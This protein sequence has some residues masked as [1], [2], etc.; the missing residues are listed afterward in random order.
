MYLQSH[1]HTLPRRRQSGRLLTSLLVVALAAFTI[2]CLAAPRL[3]FADDAE[4]TAVVEETV[5]A[6]S[7][8]SVGSDDPDKQTPVVT[9]SEQRV[10]A[11]D[12]VGS[13]DASATSVDD[14]NGSDD[15]Q[16]NSND[17]ADQQ[18]EQGAPA[19][20]NSDLADGE[21]TASDTSNTETDGASDASNDDQDAAGDTGSSSAQSDAAEEQ[22]TEDKTAE[23]NKDAQSSSATTEEK[24]DTSSSA[25]A[26]GTAI[27]E[28]IASQLK[29]VVKRLAASTSTTSIDPFVIVIDAGHGGFDSG[30]VGNDLQEHALNLSIAKHIQELLQGFANVVVYM[31]RTTNTSFTSV[32]KTDLLARVNFAVEHSAD[33]FISVHTNSG[34]SSAHGIEVIA[35]NDSSYRY[36]LHT[37][38][39]GLAN[40]VFYAERAIGLAS[41]SGVYTRDYGSGAEGKYPDGSNADYL[42]LLRNCRR[43]NIPAILIENLFI[44][45]AGD[46]AYLKSDANRLKIA[47]AIVNGIVK[48]YSLSK[49]LVSDAKGLRYLNNDKTY[50]TNTFKTVGNKTYYFGSNTYAVKWEQKINGKVYYFDSD[51]HM[52]TGWLTWNKDRTRSYFGADGAAL[53]GWQTV[54]G[55]RYYFD[56]ANWCHG[57][58]WEHK[59]NGK[60]YYFDSD[61]HMWTGWLTWNKDKTRSYF[62]SDGAAVS[63]W[64]DDGKKR[65]YI[66]P[67]TLRTVRWEHRIGGKVYYFDSD[68]HMWTGWL[69]WGKDRTR[70][71]FGAD[72]AALSGWQTV[73][74]RR[75]YFDPDNWCHGYRWEHWMGGKLYYFDADCHMWTGWLTWN[76][77]KTRSYFGADGAALSGW[78]TV[79]G[80]RYYFDPTNWCHGYRWEHRIGGKVYYFDADCH[81]WTGWLTW[82]KD[83]TRSYFGADGA[84]LSGW[85]TVGGK[86]YYFDPANWCHGLRWEHKIDGKVYYF[87][88]DCH[89]WTGWLTWKK[90][91]TRSYFGADGAA[92]SG[93]QTV[94]GKRYYFDPKNWCHGL[95]WEHTVGD[96]FYYFDS[97]CHMW[98]GW[99]T[100][101]KDKTRSYFNTD[102]SSVDYGAMLYGVQTIAGVPYDF[103]TSGKY[104]PQSIMGATQTTVTQM[105]RHYLANMGSNAYPAGVYTNKG[106]KSLNDFCQLIYE[107]A[108]AEGVRAEVLYTQVMLETG[109]LQFGGDVLPEQ[110]NFGGIGATG[111]GV[112]GNSFKDVRTGLR[113]QTQHLKAYAS[114]ELLNNACVDPRFSY[115]KRGCAPTIDGLTGTWAASSKYADSL[116][117]ILNSLLKA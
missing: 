16:T 3:A 71:Y 48:Y 18:T 109:Y 33:V 92:L 88:A 15:S 103:G 53:S 78:Q 101:K 44:S 11:A 104:Y 22:A 55:R 113:A 35:Q 4:P 64:R 61:C 111:N 14:T 30:A 107:E 8:T 75:Y 39:M 34:P 52:W 43:N 86:R 7:E 87:D 21:D 9:A 57:Y 80:K 106:A 5:E 2:A 27:A 96:N 37:E 90:D 95:R 67:S 68:C 49:N 100:W 93:W 98:T 50:A 17:S 69:T 45:N 31:T 72:G 117:S 79:G 23:N 38:S 66:N 73:G 42:S 112:R 99:L 59:V 60:L 76:R 110:C 74:G 51:Y 89:M 32:T 6:T 12:G 1:S 94:G 81:M 58:R 65:Y 62:G 83:Q 105:V 114:T 25:E 97:D 82:K 102:E 56:P 91:S 115:V 54:G 19:E 41:H 29:P 24:T 84:A 46:A 36:A 10:T 85:Q 116:K 20:D 13:S 40:A 77:D 26:A 63:G 47:Q 70:S 28:S 108:T